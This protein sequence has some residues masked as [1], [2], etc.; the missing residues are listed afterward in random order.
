MVRLGY[1]AQ[2]G[3][4]VQQYLREKTL[5]VGGLVK[6]RNI[7]GLKHTSFC[8]CPLILQFVYL[9]SFFFSSCQSVF[10]LLLVCSNCC[11]SRARRSRSRV[12]STVPTRKAIAK[13]GP[14]IS[15]APPRGLRR[16]W[17]A[18]GSSPAACVSPEIL[19]DNPAQFGIS[20]PINCFGRR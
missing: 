14:Q 13:D 3:A 7:Q 11:Q 4:R 19:P 8:G 9:S 6:Y 17:T 15:R 2:S 20:F 18:L 1:V 16:S 5:C 12:S 10:L